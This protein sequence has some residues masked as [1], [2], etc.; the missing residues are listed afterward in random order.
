MAS[1]LGSPNVASDSI[2]PIDL[3]IIKWK[4]WKRSILCRV[5]ADRGNR[6]QP[7]DQVLQEYESKTLA[8]FLFSLHI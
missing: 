7:M 2:L 1:L 4:R 3:R 8:E 6:N 5:R